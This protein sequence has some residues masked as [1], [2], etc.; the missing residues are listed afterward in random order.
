MHTKY[1]T[2]WTSE[3]HA[4]NESLGQH[5]KINQCETLNQQTKKFLKKS[6]W[7]S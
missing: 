5:L 3:V 4:K 1:N 6:K 2:S 7:S